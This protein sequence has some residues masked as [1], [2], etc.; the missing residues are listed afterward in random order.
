MKVTRSVLDIAKQIFEL[1]GMTGARE[2]CR[3]CRE[4]GWV[5]QSAKASPFQDFA[6]RN[7]AAWALE[8]AK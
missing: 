3:K 6:Q 8:V 7:A 1:H 4:G 5:Y 2:R